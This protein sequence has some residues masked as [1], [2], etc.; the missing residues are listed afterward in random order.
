MYTSQEEATLGGNFSAKLAEKQRRRRN[1]SYVIGGC[2]FS[3]RD[4]AARFYANGS[5]TL[6]GGCVLQQRL[7]TIT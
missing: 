5:G 4:I 6:E 1:V 7:G 2:F 3:R